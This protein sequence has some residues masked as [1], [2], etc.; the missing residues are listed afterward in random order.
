[1]TRFFPTVLACA[2]LAACGDDSAPEDDD[3]TEERVD[4][5]VTEPKLD[6]TVPMTRVDASVRD[7]SVARDAAVAADASGPKLH[8]KDVYDAVFNGSG[9]CSFCHPIF[10]GAIDLTSADTAYT[11]LVD[12]QTVACGTKPLVTPGDPG[13][14]YLVDIVSLDQPCAAKPQIG[15]MPNFLPPLGDTQISLIKQWITD[16]ALK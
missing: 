7:S 13:K 12:K 16:G 3:N 10:N 11:T 15:R 9:S 8:M 1:M 14:S 2:L 4:A 5:Q 6:A